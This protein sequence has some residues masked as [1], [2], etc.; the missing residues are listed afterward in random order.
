[1]H[2]RG[3]CHDA[4]AIS[5]ATDTS[6]QLPMSAPVV[7]SGMSLVDAVY[8]HNQTENM[9]SQL[10]MDMRELCGILQQEVDRIA[11][12][13]GIESEGDAGIKLAMQRAERLRRT[14]HTC[15]QLQRTEHTALLESVR[16][17]L[18]RRNSYVAS[19]ATRAVAKGMPP[20]FHVHVDRAIAAVDA[21]NATLLQT[22]PY[23]DSFSIT[24]GGVVVD[25]CSR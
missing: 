5:L 21:A 2:P 20:Q 19:I 16:D 12:A 8:T 3:C 9:L 18:M 7:R 23:N 15:A 13:T 4:G 24:T 11:S 6:V 14:L 25:T 1:M 10:A 17:D 22:V